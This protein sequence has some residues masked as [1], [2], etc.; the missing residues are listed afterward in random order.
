MRTELNDLSWKK[1]KV[2][3]ALICA[4]GSGCEESSPT[5]PQHN[6]PGIVSDT[7]GNLT[8]PAAVAEMGSI[9][10]RDLR[11]D[12]VD[13]SFAP[14]TD[15]IESASAFE[16]RVVWSVAGCDAIASFQNVTDVQEEGNDTPT[17]RVLVNWASD[18]EPEEEGGN[19]FITAT[20][21]QPDTDY[22][23]AAAAR[24]EDGDTV[25]YGPEIIHTNVGK[26]IFINEN[27]TTTGAIRYDD[28]DTHIIG[29]PA[30][31]AY[32]N[33]HK[34]LIPN[35]NLAPYKAMLVDQTRQACLSSDCAWRGAGE[36][37]DWVLKSNQ[38]YQLPR[39]ST[40]VAITATTNNRGIFTGPY[41]NVPL[42]YS[43]NEE[44]QTIQFWTGLDAEWQVSG[45]FCENW[46][47]DL[48]DDD[49]SYWGVYGTTQYDASSAHTAI[50]VYAHDCDVLQHIVCV[51][52]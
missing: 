47:Q 38:I 27:F 30:A 39:N 50:S 25:Y 34:S 10:H 46:Q 28:G 31:D 17:E 2:L 32:C 35:G 11:S 40:S 7:D 1:T 8:P 9:A 12:Q 16:Y 6:T 37:T 4:A 51:E 20:S 24:N 5:P 29:I 45:Y 52:Q 21:L 43:E 48:S 23:F 41:L 42:F 18:L 26:L 49:N 19:L 22:C 36:H 15:Y 14:A 13:I 44:S 33:L 3:L